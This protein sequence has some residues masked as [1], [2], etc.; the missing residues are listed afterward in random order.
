MST[1]LLAF[2]VALAAPPLVVAADE[3]EPGLRAWWRT[4]EL[5]VAP[6][7]G[8]PRPGVRPL[9]GTAPAALPPDL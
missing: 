2:T 1:T 8:D 7:E 9:E 3:A 4:G 6:A 5:I